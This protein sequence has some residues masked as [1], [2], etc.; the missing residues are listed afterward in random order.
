MKLIIAVVRPFILDEIVCALEEIEN[1]PGVT[2]FDSE[3][4]GQRLKTSADACSPFKPNK[5]LEIAC[6]DEMT[7]R[8]VAAIRENAHTGKRGDGIIYVV[9]VEQSVLI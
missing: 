3:G 6:E 2:V 1:F 9:P 8:I 4:F 5:R 7:E